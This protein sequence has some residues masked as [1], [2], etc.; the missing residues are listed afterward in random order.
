M[1]TRYSLFPLL[2]FLLL[3]GCTSP[4]KPE[5][6]RFQ[7]LSHYPDNAEGAKYGS[8]SLDTRT[9]VDSQYALTDRNLYLTLGGDLGF[10]NQT[11]PLDIGVERGDA[12]F[13]ENSLDALEYASRNG[14]DVVNIS[15][16]VTKAGDWFAYHDDE[17]GRAAA[18][19]QGHRKKFY[20]L[21]T[22][23]LSKLRL[24][25]RDGQLTDDRIPS[26]KEIANTWDPYLAHQRL[27][28]NIQGDA[29]LD[30]LSELNRIVKRSLASGSYFFTSGKLYQLQHLRGLD[31]EVYL[32][33]VWGPDSL[34]AQRYKRSIRQAISNDK[35]YQRNRGSSNRAIDRALAK[36]NHPKI[37][38]TEVA[39][40]LG[41]NAGLHVDIRSYAKHSTIYQRAKANN[42]SV[43]TYSINGDDYHISTLQSLASKN[44]PLPD[45]A[46]VTTSKYKVCASL[47]PRLIS[48]NGGYLPMTDQGKKISQLPRNGDFSA[49]EIQGDYLK[50]GY[51]LAIDGEVKSLTM[52]KRVVK[53]VTK[54]AVFIVEP[55]IPADTDL[56]VVF[57]P[58]HIVIP[59]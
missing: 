36:Q 28:I 59:E 23:D 34:S 26:I 52:P 14:F 9:L 49:L 7:L 20:E 44:K 47:F 19:K 5:G 41:S 46:D 12:R 24:R 57:D 38:A 53:K 8:E 30:Q 22:N 16:R 25:D 58:I 27:A 32:G 45:V 10:F 33:Y 6:D 51:Y 4:Q 54:K 13:S 15:A 56:N 11:C 43:S 31:D 37:S 17:T 55:E 42:L 3:Q 39:R 29:T 18:N 50:N 40:K 21:S 1:F 48:E 35:M 2:V